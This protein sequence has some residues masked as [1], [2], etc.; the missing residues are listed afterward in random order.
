MGKTHARTAGNHL[1]LIAMVVAGIFGLTGVGVIGYALTHQEHAPQPP[2]SVGQS[3]TPSTTPTASPTDTSTVNPTGGT[4]AAPTDNPTGA[5]AT[6]DPGAP[7]KADK[8]KTTGRVMSRSLPVSLSIPAIHVQTSLL[9]LGQTAQG[10][11]QVP[12]PGPD[13][14]KAAW[15]RL[16]PTPGE[17]GPAILVGHIDSAAKGISV[18]F[19]LGALKPHDTVRV[20]RADG[21]VAVFAV[22]EVRRFHKQ[23]FPTKLVYSNTDHAAL[24]IITCGG[25]FDRDSG[26]YLDNTIVLAS[27]VS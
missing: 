19:Y 21:S 18:F 23:D 4:G 7:P 12:P 27:L 20:T 26:S 16:S 1:G 13:Y 22:D 10:T 3:A 15:Y 11:L 25:A 5:G 9:H 2:L 8:P 6:P 24:R 17:L 14:D